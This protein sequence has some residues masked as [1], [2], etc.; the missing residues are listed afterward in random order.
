MRKPLL[1]FCFVVPLYLFTYSQFETYCDKQAPKISFTGKAPW[2]IDGR[3]DDWQTILGPYAG[4]K[5]PFVPNLV[6][7]Y[8]PP[9]TSAFNWVVDVNIDDNYPN[10]A[11]S[12][13]PAPQ[14]DLF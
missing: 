2:H 14:S 11:V 4:V 9:Q 12:P 8:T 3:V 10:T 7:P 6:Y 5:D 1:L 13:I